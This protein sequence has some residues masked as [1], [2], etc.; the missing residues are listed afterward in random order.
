MA[1]NNAYKAGGEFVYVQIRMGPEEYL[2]L[3]DASRILD[4]SIPQF[5]RK[6]LASTL[7]H[8]VVEDPNKR[9][10]DE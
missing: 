10:P 7:P 1:N 6:M 8:Y 3:R 5:I 9:P 4:V 2:R